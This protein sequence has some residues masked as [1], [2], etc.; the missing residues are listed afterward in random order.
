MAIFHS[1]VD[2]RAIE[3]PLQMKVLMGK[4]YKWWLPLPW[5]IFLPVTI[6]ILVIYGIPEWMLLDMNGK[7]AYIVTNG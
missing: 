3:N 6:T 2:K 5:L 1:Y 7:G 4:S